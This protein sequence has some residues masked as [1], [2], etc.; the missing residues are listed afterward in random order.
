MQYGIRNKTN[1]R[2]PLLRKVSDGERAIYKHYTVETFECQLKFILCN[3]PFRTCGMSLAITGPQQRRRQV[4]VSVLV[5]VSHPEHPPKTRLHCCCRFP[6]RDTD[7]ASAET[8]GEKRD[9]ITQ[10]ILSGLPFIHSH[11]QSLSSNKVRCGWYSG[12]STRRCTAS[13]IP[14]TKADCTA[15]EA[16]LMGQ[17][18]DTL[19]H[20]LFRHPDTGTGS[21]YYL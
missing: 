8:E 4:W 14:T 20:L 19:R 2:T 21:I 5:A 1:T 11:R 6:D 17:D 3:M 12:C 18:G 13:R 9:W 16:S 15:T 10:L 7:K